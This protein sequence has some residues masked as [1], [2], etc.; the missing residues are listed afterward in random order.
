MD[1]KEILKTILNAAA[2]YHRNLES[3][4]YI[5]LFNS[6]NAR[7]E[8]II[9][10]IETMFLAS[11]FLH[12]TGVKTALSPTD[13]YRN[14]LE[15]RLSVKHF[16]I[17]DEIVCERKMSV[18]PYVMNMAENCKM[19]GD[20]QNQQGIFLHTDKLVGGIRGALGFVVSNNAPGYYV[21]NTALNEDIRNLSAKTYR[22]LAMFSKKRL[23]NK[24]TEPAVIVKNADYTAILDYLCKINKV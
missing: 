1:K 23:E 11:N 17:Q 2:L 7:G 24:Y 16:D 15:H 9:S 13:F 21:P 10:H 22:I 18:L 8:L 4:N 6:S 14:S 3:K 20:F 12:L 19:L 5:I